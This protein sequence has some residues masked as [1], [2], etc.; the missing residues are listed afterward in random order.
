MSRLKVERVPRA[1]PGVVV[2]ALVGIAAAGCSDSARFDS[3]SYSS[4]RPA[5][6]QNVA[7]TAAPPPAPARVE[8]QPLPSVAQPA[9]VSAAPGTYSTPAPAYYRPTSQNSD[10]TGSVP[11]TPA[12]GHWTW[13]GG[14]SE[15]PRHGGTKDTPPRA[16]RDPATDRLHPHGIRDPSQIK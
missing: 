10:V 7:S 6:P 5:P 8:A 9:T 14:S 4:D 13:N 16:P 15:S 3:S 12:R 2:L 1:W 11:S